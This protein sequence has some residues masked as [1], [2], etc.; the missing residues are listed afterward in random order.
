MM[1]VELRAPAPGNGF[2]GTAAEFSLGEQTAAAEPGAPE[3]T[4]RSFGDQLDDSLMESEADQEPP[5]C[6][7]CPAVQL[8][9]LGALRAFGP[10]IDLGRVAAARV[11]EEVAPATAPTIADTVESIASPSP[12][13]APVDA[14]VTSAAGGT[15]VAEGHGAMAVV[16]GPADGPSKPRDTVVPPGSRDTA[17]AQE[18]R[19]TSAPPALRGTA[20][21][22]APAGVAAGRVPI[23]GAVAREPVE[24]AP[25]PRV[26]QDRSRKEEVLTEAPPR[27]EIAPI[28][29]DRSSDVGRPSGPAHAGATGNSHTMTAPVEHRTG[30]DAADAPEH[31]VTANERGRLA[32]RA[33]L[34]GSA[35]SSIGAGIE[36]SVPGH[37][38]DS[39]AGPRGRSS[40]DPNDGGGRRGGA[41]RHPMPSMVVQSGTGAEAAP[42][43]RTAAGREQPSQPPFQVEPSA[44]PEGWPRAALDPGA[45]VMP[46]GPPPPAPQVTLMPPAAEALDVPR[47]PVAPDTADSIVQSMR[48]QYQRGGGEAVVHIKPE[49]LGPVSVSLRVENGVVSAV[50]HAGSGEVAEWL[51]AN[52]QVL[53]DGLASSGLHLERFAVRRDGHPPDRR[54]WR[55][56]EP[57]ERRRRGLQPE[58]TF[59]ISV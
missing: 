8:P 56:P 15:A 11:V 47:A 42:I 57:P 14:S 32:A 18:P 27:A 45:R 9:L 48:L 20:V 59:E 46:A 16:P 29:R 12:L 7:A 51:K 28:V 36:E 39:P 55:P 34:A 38:T 3:A 23:N 40:A 37:Q 49:H 33:D 50:V 17:V 6:L 52:E 43:D 25:N 2:G 26:V 19:D 24:D 41:D 13:S 54:G 10:P 53:R 31:R 4:P 58:S 21:A 35:D 1:S 44:A 30:T 22:P 5:A